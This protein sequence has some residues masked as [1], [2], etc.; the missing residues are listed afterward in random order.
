MSEMRNGLY[1]FHVIAFR[2]W[3]VLDWATV[4]STLRSPNVQVLCPVHPS[5]VLLEVS[6]ALLLVLMIRAWGS[7]GVVLKRRSNCPN[8]ALCTTRLASSGP[9]TSEPWHSILKPKICVHNIQK[10]SFYLK[11]RSLIL[12]FKDQS[13]NAVQ[14]NN[15]SWLW[16]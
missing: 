8:P 14:G 7:G 15:S 11:R 4:C 16:E 5:N 12:Q 1:S 13:V 6:Q 2:A 3:A 9:L 10:V